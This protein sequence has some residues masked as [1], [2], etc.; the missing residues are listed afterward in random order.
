MGNKRQYKTISLFTAGAITTVSITLV[1]FLLGTTFLVWFTGSGLSSYLKEKQEISVELSD[2]ITA[3]DAARIQKELNKNPYIKSTTYI[4]KEDVKADLIN[5]LGSNPDELV[6]FGWEKS[7]IDIAVRAEYM[8][9]DSIGKVVR[10]LKG[11]DFNLVSSVIYKTEDIVLVSS[12]L[13]KLILVLLAFTVILIIISFVLIRSI[14]QLNIYSKRFTINTMQ[15]VGATNGF[16]RRPF[17]SRM[18]LCGILASILANL[19]IAGMLYS[20][21]KVMPDIQEMITQHQVYMVFGLV[22]LCGILI[23]V[24]ATASAVNRYLKMTTNKLYRD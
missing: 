16:I 11:K 23:P 22:L 15:L 20:I 7:Y 3:K 13:S 1:L 21:I 5:E 12:N 14:I 18:V 2:N 4:S 9:P 8:N 24:F 17:M 19:G 6:G 10:S